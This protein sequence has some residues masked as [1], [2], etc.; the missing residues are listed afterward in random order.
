MMK[1]NEYSM[2]MKQQKTVGNIWM[3]LALCGPP[4]TSDMTSDWVLINIEAHI[5][6]L[7]VK[8]ASNMVDTMLMMDNRWVNSGQCGF[9][10][11][12]SARYLP[13]MVCTHLVW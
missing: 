3:P 1:K 4:T 10:V 13:T 8:M 6:S 5:M 12:E 2:R 9:V 11:G 7:W